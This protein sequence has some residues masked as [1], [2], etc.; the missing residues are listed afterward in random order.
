MALA[1]GADIA[2]KSVFA[3]K[4]YFYPDLPKGFQTT[5]Y[6]LPYCNGGGIKLDSGRIIDVERIHFEEDAG[7]SIH[8]DGVSYVDLNR[9]GTPLLEMVS[10]PVIH[11][12][13]EASEYLRKVRSIVRYLD[14]SDGNLEEGS[15]RCDANVSLKPKG[16]PTLGTRT[17]IKNV[18]SFRN[19][20][21]AITYEIARQADVLQSGDKVIQQT[22]RFDAESGKTMVSRSKEQTA[23]YRY[24]PEPDLGPLVISESRISKIRDQL[25]ELPEAVYGRFLKE[26]ELSLEHCQILVEEKE[27]SDYFSR[28]VGHLDGL[29]PKQAANF[30]VNEVLREARENEWDMT[31]PPL[32]PKGVAEL[33]NLQGSGKIS[34]K[35]AKKVLTQM[36]ETKQSAEEIVEKEGL[37]QVSDESAIAEALTKILDANPSQVAAYLG[38][39]EKILGFFVGQ[40]MKVSKGKFNPGLVNKILKEKLDE[41]R[42]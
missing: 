3:R 7:K 31:N 21:R 17:E 37:V 13:Q 2:E 36:L 8:G 23:D 19:V 6:D 15:F 35:I 11:S 18:N 41:R 30:V 9:A 27:V 32:A 29:A 4:Q 42:S 24:F 10:R 26:L 22:M 16:S 14:I 33:L 20:E 28:I 40:V 12:A 39:K 25:P 34:G 5:Q 1:I 38:G